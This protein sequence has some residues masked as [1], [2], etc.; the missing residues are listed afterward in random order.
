MRQQFRHACT[1]ALPDT[2]THAHARVWVQEGMVRGG[3]TPGVQG[4][5]R[6]ECPS[7]RVRARPGHHELQ[8]HPLP[9]TGHDY[10]GPVA[11]PMA[12]PKPSE[13]MHRTCCAH[14]S[15]QRASLHATQQ[16]AGGK[17]AYGV[18]RSALPVCTDTS[19][20]V[21]P[22]AA[23]GVPPLCWCAAGAAGVRGRGGGAHAARPGGAARGREAHGAPQ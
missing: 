11:L 16:A 15:P 21:R 8:Q 4:C 23:C 17:E 6:S 7:E 20:S 2:R 12:P 5:C 14:V 18:R 19:S 1:H 22:T 13:V 3:G 9:E 10:H